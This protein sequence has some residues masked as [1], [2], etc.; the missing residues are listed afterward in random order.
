M[1]RGAGVGHVLAP[2][3]ILVFS[4]IALAGGA[5]LGLHPQFAAAVPIEGRVRHCRSAPLG[6]SRFDV[7]SMDV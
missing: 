4:F 7:G 3:P 1:R 6:L 2:W 5:L